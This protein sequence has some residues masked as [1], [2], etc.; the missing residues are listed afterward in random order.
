MNATVTHVRMEVRVWMDSMST[1][2]TARTSTLASTVKEVNH[3]I[4]NSTLTSFLAYMITLNIKY[5]I[6]K[7]D[8]FAV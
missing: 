4:F 1:P 3:F 7:E 2:V 8:N 6:I 5:V